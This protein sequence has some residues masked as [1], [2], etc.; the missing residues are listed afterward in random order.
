MHGRGSGWRIEA[1]TELKAIELLSHAKFCDHG[2]TLDSQYW[3]KSTK[4]GERRDG[5]KLNG[6]SWVVAFLPDVFGIERSRQ[7]RDSRRARTSLDRF[8][9]MQIED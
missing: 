2:P 9:P 3:R 1:A 6:A 5:E 4:F 7:G 8:R